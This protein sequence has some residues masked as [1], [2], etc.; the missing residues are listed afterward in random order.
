M[1]ASFCLFDINSG[2]G[3]RSVHGSHLFFGK[4]VFAVA[5]PFEE[6]KLK[7]KNTTNVVKWA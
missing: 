7:A 1:K 6:T 3:C 2:L 4:F 5:V